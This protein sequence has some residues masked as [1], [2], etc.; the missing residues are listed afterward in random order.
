MR[1]KGLGYTTLYTGRLAIGGPG[2][3]KCHTDNLPKTFVDADNARMNTMQL[4]AKAFTLPDRIDN[5]FDTG[6]H[7]AYNHGPT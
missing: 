4:N 7:Q 5:S 2:I 6:N 1:R 3:N